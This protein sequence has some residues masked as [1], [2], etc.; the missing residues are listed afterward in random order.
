MR[1][2]H[3]DL[4]AAL[5]RKAESDWQVILSGIEHGLPVDAICDAKAAC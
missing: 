5:A 1:K 4:A 3:L 2:T